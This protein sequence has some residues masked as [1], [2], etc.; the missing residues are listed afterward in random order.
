MV[1]AASLADLITRVCSILFC[2][3]IVQVM[4]SP[5]PC[6]LTVRRAMV[7]HDYELS[8]TSSHKLMT[9]I[10]LQ[11]ML[12]F[13]PRFCHLWWLDRIH[14]S[15]FMFLICP[16]ISMMRLTTP[17][18]PRQRPPSELAQAPEQAGTSTAH[19]AC[20]RNHKRGPRQDTAYRCAGN[21]CGDGTHGGILCI[22]HQSPEDELEGVAEGTEEGASTTARGR[23]WRVGIV[24]ELEIGFC[25]L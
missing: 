19:D 6:N 2:R 12:T 5:R 11:C 16:G 15:S 22:P 24:E 17:N 3:K 25:G 9:L 7:V 4:F 14:V 13:S 23:I 10:S 1:P 20:W 21:C 8:H 18:L